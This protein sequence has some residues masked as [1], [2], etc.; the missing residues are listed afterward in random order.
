MLTGF[1]HHAGIDVFVNKTKQQQQ[2]KT[3][4]LLE[5]VWQLQFVDIP[6]DLTGHITGHLTTSRQRHSCSF[7]HVI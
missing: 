6:F 3:K 5:T 1:M 7:T 4:S 2:R